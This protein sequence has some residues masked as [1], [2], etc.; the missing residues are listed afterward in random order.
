MLNATEAT[1]A[2]LSKMAIVIANN[3]SVSKE[4]VYQG[5][6]APVRPA[7]ADG[8][9]GRLAV[10]IASDG[11]VVAGSSERGLR[12]APARYHAR[13]RLVAKFSDRWS[14]KLSTTTPAVAE[15]HE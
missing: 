9:V 4:E 13:K 2:T 3:L 8:I 11:Q 12:R 6:S 1:T 7:I 5:P 10:D 15:R 14:P